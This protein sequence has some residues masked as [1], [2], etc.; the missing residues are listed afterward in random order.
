MKSTEPIC[1]E[2]EEAD[3]RDITGEAVIEHAEQRRTGRTGAM[4]MVISLIALAA[5]IGGLMFG[6]W[7]LSSMD[8]SVQALT[9]SFSGTEQRSG[10]LFSGM[11]AASQSLE[12]QLA[13]LDAHRSALE[14]RERW[15][16]EERDRLLREGEE[17]R[18]AL[19]SVTDRMGK[20]GTDW[21]VAEA[22]Y[23]LSVAE[24]RLSLDHDPK[25][26]LLA[27][28]AAQERLEATG[29]PAWQETRAILQKEIGKLEGSSKVNTDRVASRVVQL[30]QT[31]D[32]LKIRGLS[33]NPDERSGGSPSPTAPEER[34]VETLLHDSWEGFKSI[35]VIRRRGQPVNAVLS[36]QQQYFVYQNIRLQLAVAQLSLIYENQSLYETSLEMVSHWLADYFDQEDET[37][38]S[39][40][41]EI[42]KLQSMDI[43]SESADFLSSLSALR[44]NLSA[45]GAPGGGGG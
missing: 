27:M 23:L 22:D 28:R 31:V 26:A 13:R 41:A 45:T 29:D 34:S 5:T 44:A 2:V 9:Q 32:Q 33:F 11:Q 10:D 24:H 36:P 1:E 8:A 30:V 15:L 21:M 39:F 37:T 7:R 25:T 12:Q 3:I 40:S 14:D 4:A 35:M 6:Y 20:S 38:R 16:A 43:T 19:A 17:I 42:G 18:S